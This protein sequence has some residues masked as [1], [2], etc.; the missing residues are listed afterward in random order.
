MASA[1]RNKL[2]Y[3]VPL[4]LSAPL[5]AGYAMNKLMLAGLPGT[6]LFP[7]F[8]YLPT[9]LTF[10]VFWAWVGSLF[11]RLNVKKIYGFLLGNSTTVI[12]ALIFTW[13]FCFEQ[14]EAAMAISPWLV[15]SCQLFVLPMANLSARILS[16]LSSYLHSN[17]A[18]LGAYLLLVIAFSAGFF[19][20]VRRE[21]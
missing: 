12:F 9:S 6:Q 16:I 10:A 5:I 2:V 14:Q 1:R 19:Y 7:V 20:R 13:I 3:A 18:I 11:A 17:V 8:L 15:L 4:L 21:I